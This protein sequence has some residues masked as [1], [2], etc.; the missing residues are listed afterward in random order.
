MFYL[1][2]SWVPT[3]LIY[4]ATSFVRGNTWIIH[5]TWVERFI[6]FMPYGIWLY[7]LFYIYIPYTFL[8]VN[9]SRI[10]RITWVFI[11]TGCISGIIFIFLPSSII[12]PELKVDG[13]SA[14]LLNFIY[15]N[16]TD[17]NCFPSM[18]GSLITICTLANWDKTRKARSYGCIL[19][20]LMMYYSIVQ[21]RQHL[22]IDVAAGIVLGTLVWVISGFILNK[23][24]KSD[25]M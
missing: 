9:E 19:L 2:I 4:G 24:E 20:T 3:C 1:F 11:V 5:E 12:F 22:F 23:T 15:E 8:T 14:S 17:Q 25:V 16:D 10:K 13:V 6:P 21:I 18:H 7:I